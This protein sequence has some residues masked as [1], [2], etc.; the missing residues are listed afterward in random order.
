[1]AIFQL[2]LASKVVGGDYF[3]HRGIVVAANG[4]YN[5]AFYFVVDDCWIAFD[6]A[7]RSRFICEALNF[8]GRIGFQFITCFPVVVSGKFEVECARIG[9]EADFFDELFAVAVSCDV[10]GSF[11]EASEE[12]AF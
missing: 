11:A 7:E 1:M 3:H 2:E 5:G 4:S 6:R 9:V 10:V 12:N 8:D